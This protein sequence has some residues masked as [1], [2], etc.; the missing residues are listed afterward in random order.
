LASN[1]ESGFSD[2]HGQVN[3][4]FEDQLDDIDTT[5][6]AISLGLS[7]FCTKIGQ[8]GKKISPFRLG[9]EKDASP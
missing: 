5:N 2:G 8:N 3:C 9:D 7:Y 1:Y 6:P 4:V